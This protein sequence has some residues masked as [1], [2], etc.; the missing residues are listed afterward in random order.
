MKKYIVIYHAPMEAIAR[1]QNMPPEESRK[2][3][4][5][6]MQWAENCG[7]HLVDHGTPLGFGQRL[8]VDGTSQNSKRQV[9][10]Y[11]VLQAENMEQARALLLGHPH[12]SGWDN[13]CEIEVHVSLPLP[14]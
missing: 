11:S 6:W 2:G 4:E 12:L 7:D 13:A 5:I 9:C 1:M 3:M 8:N 10:G 14:G